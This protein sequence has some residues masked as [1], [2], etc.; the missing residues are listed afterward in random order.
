MDTATLYNEIMNYQGQNN[1][2]LSIRISLSKWGRLTPGQI[3]AATRCFAPIAKKEMKE[4][5]V[6]PEIQKILDYKGGNT[7]V[8]DIKKK[9]ETFK[10]LS[11]KQIEVTNK[12]ITKEEEAKKREPEQQNEPE[13][14]APKPMALQV[15]G[16]SNNSFFGSEFVCV[17]ER[18]CVC[19]LGCPEE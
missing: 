16:C 5:P 7:F 2:L 15:V 18:A 9:Y 3:S 11:L 10:Y 1:F 13:P 19:P 14:M 4:Q 8:L 17:C 6:T 12:A